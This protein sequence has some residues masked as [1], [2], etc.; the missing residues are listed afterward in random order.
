MKT[1][2]ITALSFALLPLASACAHSAGTAPHEMSAADHEN[3]AANEE[4][5]SAKHANQYDGTA[6]EPGRCGAGRAGNPCWSS[7]SNPTA[8]HASDAHHH[9][10]LAAKHR[11]ASEALR[12]AEDQACVGIS[13]ED[14]EMSPFSHYDDVETVAELD[15]SVATGNT[16]VSSVKEVSETRETRAGKQQQTNLVG[17]EVVFRAVPGLTAEWLQRVVNCHI[18]RNAALGPAV[19]SADMPHCPLAVDGAKASVS[20]VGNGFAVT[21]RA[22]SAESAKE[23]VRRAQ[24]LKT[25]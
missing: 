4:K 9:H 24:A 3:A 11:A 7:L 17:A 20:S 15:K 25:Q 16:E 2:F 5:E 21:I 22:D 8:E 13:E 14:R 10:E 6:T 12:Q 19:A 18:A 1:S 23:I